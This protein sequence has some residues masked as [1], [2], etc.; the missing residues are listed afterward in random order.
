MKNIFTKITMALNLHPVANFLAKQKVNVDLKTAFNI[1][2]NF[3]S[4]SIP[5]LI[6]LYRPEQHLEASF[7]YTRN[8]NSNIYDHFSDAISLF[9]NEIPPHRTD[10]SISDVNA[11][12]MGNAEL[13]S[14]SAYSSIE[15]FHQHSD[16]HAD[17]F[18]T[19][20]ESEYIGED[21]CG[22]DFSNDDYIRFKL[23]GWSERLII[24]ANDGHHR[25]AHAAVLAKKLQKDLKVNA[26][27]EAIVF[28]EHTFNDFTAQF[29]QFLV[30][31]QINHG[32]TEVFDELELDYISISHPVLVDCCLMIIPRET[33]P[34]DIISFLSK[35]LTDFNQILN[36]L[37]EVQ[38]NSPIYHKYIRHT[39]VK[40]EV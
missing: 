36:D 17:P 19:E 15:E 32:L 35:E 31:L 8:Q 23:Y 14:L 5:N 39:A 11:Y 16:K 21:Q 13:Y 9:L 33:V 2:D 26:Q 20:L 6:G 29:A 1:Q 40:S 10:I 30:P 4:E 25:F 27:F 7:F 3:N 18:G 24:E 38:V 12:K 37:L 28:N 34:T 22:I